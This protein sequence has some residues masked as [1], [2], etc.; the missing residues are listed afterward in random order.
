MQQ[1]LEQSLASPGSLQARCNVRGPCRLSSRRLSKRGKKLPAV[2]AAT[3][4]PPPAWPGRA[5]IKE[6]INNIRLPKVGSKTCDPMSISVQLLREGLN[7]EAA[8][9]PS[10]QF[11]CASYDDGRAE[12]C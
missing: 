12:G 3:H 2:R 8:L 4:G 10:N 6:D 7:T 1:A 5:V 11:G 9:L